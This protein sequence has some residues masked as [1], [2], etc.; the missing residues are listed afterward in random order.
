V[1]NRDTAVS[2]VVLAGTVALY[3]TLSMFHPGAVIF[4]RVIV[5]IIGLLA[6]LL[7][8]QSI[9]LKHGIKGSGTAQV[10]AETEK[11]SVSKKPHFAWKPVLLIFGAILVYFFVMEQLGFYV[12]AFLYFVGVVFLLDWRGLTPKKGFMRIGIAFV[13]TALVYLLFSVILL[14]QTPRGLLL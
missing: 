5:I 11:V 13:F 10:P 2:L 1:I 4:I 6:L 12:S 8:A 3:L 14:V 7:L 9:L